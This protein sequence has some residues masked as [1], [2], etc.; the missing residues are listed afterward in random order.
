MAA[1]RSPGSE[2]GFDGE[3]FASIDEVQ[4]ADVKGGARTRPR[5][6]MR[7]SLPVVAEYR[8]GVL[9]IIELLQLD[10][11]RA[12][13][14]AAAMGYDPPITA[15]GVVVEGVEAERR[16]G[17]GVAIFGFSRAE[18]LHRSL[19]SIFFSKTPIPH[20]GR[21]AG[22][23]AAPRAPGSIRPSEAAGA[24][25]P[26]RRPF[27]RGNGFLFSFLLFFFLLFEPMICAGSRMVPDDASRR[28][29]VARDTIREPASTVD[30]VDDALLA[31]I[32]QAGRAAEC[33]E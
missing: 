29:H 32:E 31:E 10:M 7:P 22:A 26:L 13:F 8:G 19:L 28:R 12:V 18:L 20:R 11:R 2:G 9:R 3:A 14:I 24:S 15:R 16:A 4:G 30:S 5:D 17:G 1:G 25:H 23:K 6:D 27:V 21:T 33:V